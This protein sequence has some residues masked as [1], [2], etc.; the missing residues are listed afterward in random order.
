VVL[1]VMHKQLVLAALAYDAVPKE[2]Q[3]H[4]Q[5]ALI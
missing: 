3:S 2:E 4:A 1:L 5:T